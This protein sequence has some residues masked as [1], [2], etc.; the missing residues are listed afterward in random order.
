MGRDRVGE[1]R[2]G[3]TTLFAGLNEGGMIAAYLFG[4]HTTGAAHPESDVDVAVLLD[5][6][7]YRTPRARFDRR[8][9]LATE[10]ID[11]LHLA[12]VDVVVL[13]DIP[14]GFARRILRE[15]LRIYCANAMTERAFLRDTELKVS[16]LKPFLDRARKIKLASLA[17]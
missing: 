6:T 17:R 1:A 7:T 8:V 13:N 10:L 11:A 9:E 12:A 14:P 5:Y 3:L 15:G 16:D 4:S 2:D